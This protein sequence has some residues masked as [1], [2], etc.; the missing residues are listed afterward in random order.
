VDVTWSGLTGGNPAAAH[1][2]CC[3]PRGANIGV[4]VGFPSFPATL[5]GTYQHDFDLLDTAIYTASFLSN[6]GGGSASGARDALI[7]G[8]ENQQAYVNIHNAIFPGG[9]I[10][11]NVVPE[12]STLTLLGVAFAATAAARR[13]RA[14]A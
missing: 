2:H 8:L 4:A 11:G 6:F 1:I 14:R 12:P 3:T 7:T 5:S 13:R 10:R 9:E